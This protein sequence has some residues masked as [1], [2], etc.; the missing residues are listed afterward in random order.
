MQRLASL[1]AESSK[2]QDHCIMY[3]IIAGRIMYRLCMG[4]MPRGC[5]YPRLD[6]TQPPDTK[7]F[8]NRDLRARLLAILGYMQH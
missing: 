6:A 4:R 5:V 1:Y 8:K 7:K 3:V 2:S